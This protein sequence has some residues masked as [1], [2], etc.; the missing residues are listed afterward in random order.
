[1]RSE[2]FNHP[3][4]IT[5]AETLS[6]EERVRLVYQRLDALLEIYSE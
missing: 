6:Y 2:L 5:R 1:M 4:F 3:A